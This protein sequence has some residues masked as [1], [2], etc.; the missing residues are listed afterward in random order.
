MDAPANRDFLPSKVHLEALGIGIQ[1]SYSEF[2]GAE[3]DFQDAGN[4]FS[5]KFG[6]HWSQKLLANTRGAATVQIQNVIGV[7][8]GEGW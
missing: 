1:T 4:D 6:M 2:Q 3:N 8:C 7:A 5:L